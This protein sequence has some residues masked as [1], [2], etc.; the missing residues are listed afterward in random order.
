MTTT[1]IAPEDIN[2]QGYKVFLAGAIDMGKAVDWQSF[3]IQELQGESQLVLINPRRENFTPDTL[4][5]QI[6]WELNAL[7]TVDLIFMWFPKD[8]KAPISFFESG[9]YMTSGKLLLGAEQGFYRRRNLEL[10]TQHHKVKLHD[11][12]TVMIKYLKQWIKFLAITD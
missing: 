12:L 3:V 11:N 10:T 5:E 2:V 8:A 9:L 1:I 6:L 4:D 7:D